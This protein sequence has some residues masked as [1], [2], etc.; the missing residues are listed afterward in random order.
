MYSYVGCFINAFHSLHHFAISQNMFLPIV[1]G[2]ALKIF[3]PPPASI[4]SATTKGKT[5][6]LDQAAT[7]DGM[8]AAF[9]KS[10][11]HNSTESFE[12]SPIEVDDITLPK[13]KAAAP[14]FWTTKKPRDPILCSERYS[15]RCNRT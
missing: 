5:K 3:L 2:N 6:A 11:Y 14:P 8:A 12:A 4:K 1:N 10:S 13:L 15:Q 9:D 7:V